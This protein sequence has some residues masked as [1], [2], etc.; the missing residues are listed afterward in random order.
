M[1][2]RAFSS[3]SFALPSTNFSLYRYTLSRIVYRYINL[4]IN[5][6]PSRTATYSSLS[7]TIYTRTTSASSLRLA[8]PNLTCKTNRTPAQGS[9]TWTGSNWPIISPTCANFCTQVT[10]FLY[11]LRALPMPSWSLHELRLSLATRSTSKKNLG[12]NRPFFRIILSNFEKTL[13]LGAQCFV[14]F[15]HKLSGGLNPT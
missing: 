9:P 13:V 3:P 5:S 1:S 2:L 7:L 14:C 8:F 15:V 4:E 6:V 10:I 11:S 12:F